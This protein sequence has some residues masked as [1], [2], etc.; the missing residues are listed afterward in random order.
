MFNI[1]AGGLGIPG[2]IIA[3]VLV[4]VWRA[5]RMGLDTRSLA[6]AVIPGIPLAQAIGRLGNYFNQELFGRRTDLPW[7]LSV[8]P[9]HRPPDDYS[10]ESVLYHPTFLYEAIW[11][12]GVLGLLLWLDSTRRLR[13]GA[14]LWIYIAAYSLGRL[15]VES[16]RID[17][18]T[19]IG[20]WR[21]NTW[22]S[23]FGIAVG[24]V[25]LVVN[26]RTPAA[27]I[28]DEDG[29]TLVQASA[30]SGLEHDQQSE[31]RDSVGPLTPSD[32]SDPSVVAGAAHDRMTESA[33]GDAGDSEAGADSGNSEA[34]A[35]SGD[36]EA[37]D[38]E[39]GDSE[40]GGSGP[41]G[42]GHN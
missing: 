11:N 5:R 21:V 34:G 35:D 3:G 41:G 2:G 37:G 6:D 12:L 27:P 13:R 25:G 23:L 26:S 29:P 15:W 19:T 38:S 16:L 18:A 40:A 14:L 31:G 7:G 39:A 36:S 10:L 9:G 17:S 22:M 20:G 1:R 24:L 42:S 8:D 32:D 4:G 28:L 33:A 30:S